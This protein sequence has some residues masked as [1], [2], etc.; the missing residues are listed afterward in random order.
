MRKRIH[1]HCADLYAQAFA[2]WL[3]DYH[4]EQNPVEVAL[5]RRVQ[6]TRLLAAATFWVAYGRALA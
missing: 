3:G 5:W 1:A 6:F 2:D 4:H